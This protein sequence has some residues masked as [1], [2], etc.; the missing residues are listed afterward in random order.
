MSEQLLGCQ[1]LLTVK[2]SRSH[3]HT[4]FG[5]TPPDE[6]SARRPD[7]YQT[8]HN[9][10]NRH[11]GAPGG[12]RTRNPS[13]RAA[14][15]PRLRQRG[16]WDRLRIKHKYNLASI[17]WKG[18]WCLN[19]NT[20]QYTSNGSKSSLYTD[21]HSVLQVLRQCRWTSDWC[22]GT[23]VGQGTTDDARWLKRCSVFPFLPTFLNWP[24]TQDPTFEH[25]RR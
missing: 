21:S 16:H 11:I 24:A 22:A 25:H 6:W 20:R 18:S 23:H 5:R 3:W 1:D 2:A 13:K 12:I 9:I 17:G 19:Y 4:T 7:L 14:A 10:H 15:D 8:T